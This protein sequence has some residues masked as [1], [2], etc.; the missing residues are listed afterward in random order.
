MT[1]GLT[2]YGY[3]KMIQLDCFFRDKTLDLTKHYVRHERLEFVALI[4]GTHL[5]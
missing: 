4:S 1:A 2:K 3:H 5:N